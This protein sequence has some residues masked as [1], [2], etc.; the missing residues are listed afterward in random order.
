MEKIGILCAMD[1]EAEL[2]RSRLTDRLPDLKAA[3]GTISRGKLSGH[4]VALTVCGIGKVNCAMSAQALID[5]CQVGVLINTGI[6]GGLGEGLRT[7]D[8]VA[9]EQLVE[10]DFDL[11]AVGEP[12]GCVPGHEEGKPTYFPTSER[13]LNVY[14]KAAESFTESRF[15]SGT[16][17]SG[18]MFLANPAYKQ[19]LRD[20]FHAIAGEMEGVAAARVALANGV[21]S[22][23]LRAISDLADGDAAMTYDVF[24]KR[25]ADLSAHVLLRMIEL[26]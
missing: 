13:L 9:A 14:R 4:D 26:L 8:L 10:H 25:A 24:E 5:L 23:V 15:W 12:K 3:G 7:L 19:S 20:S 1:V 11:T 2:L 6:A 21:E 22:F 17:A 16:I 18:D